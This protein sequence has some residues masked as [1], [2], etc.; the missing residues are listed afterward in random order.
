M[1]RRLDSRQPDYITRSPDQPKSNLHLSGRVWNEMNARQ[2]EL[3][4]YL[5]EADRVRNSSSGIPLMSASKDQYGEI[6]RSKPNADRHQARQTL[7]EEEDQDK[8]D[9]KVTK[10]QDTGVKNNAK[11]DNFEEDNLSEMQQRF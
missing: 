4:G 9:E 11:E 8:V 1:P 6:S 3:W 10:E 5:K 7:A 2:Q